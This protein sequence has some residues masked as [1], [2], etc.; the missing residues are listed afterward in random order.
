[1]TNEA[2]RNKDTIEPLV[3]LALLLVGLVMTM[4]GW[5]LDWR[6]YVQGVGGGMCIVLTVWSGFAVARMLKLNTK[7]QFREERA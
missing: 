6:G 4:T 3:R 2:K 7:A 5:A 1:M